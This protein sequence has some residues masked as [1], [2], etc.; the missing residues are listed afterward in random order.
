MLKTS[1]LLLPAERLEVYIFE[2]SLERIHQLQFKYGELLFILISLMFHKTVSRLK[3]S[4]FL[5]GFTQVRQRRLY[6]TLL[7]MFGK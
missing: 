6:S 5:Q 2:V 1:A 4:V 3:T 7:E